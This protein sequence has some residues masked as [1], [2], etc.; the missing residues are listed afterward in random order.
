MARLFALLGVVL[1]A[2]C[3]AQQD[4]EAAPSEMSRVRDLADLLTPVEEAR[5]AARLDKAHQLYGPEVGIVTVPS[6]DGK[7]IA[8]FANDY[9]NAS[10][11]GAAGR[12]DGLVILV[13][14]KEQQVRIGATSGIDRAYSDAW[15]QDVIDGV[16]LEHFR[17][18][19]WNRG[20]AAGLDL[21]IGH[22]K[23]H[24]TRPPNHNAPATE[25]K[26]V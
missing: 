25:S 23:Q 9:A 20:L 10:G 18:Q 17:Q 8:Q 13:A 26:A 12:H 16:M 24:P 11:L 3:S 21:I 19:H 1:L 6:L 5:L 22:M 4:G 15:A 14:P 7:P 2:A